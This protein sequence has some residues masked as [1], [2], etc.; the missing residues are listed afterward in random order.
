MHQRLSLVKAPAALGLQSIQR[1]SMQAA[2]A[3]PTGTLGAVEDAE[4]FL[5]SR[6]AGPVKCHLHVLSH[7]RGD[8]ICNETQGGDN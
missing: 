4:P 2:G 7:W 5:C 8:D 3:A 1:Y 6:S